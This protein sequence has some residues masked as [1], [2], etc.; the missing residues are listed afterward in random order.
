MVSF[1]STLFGFIRLIAKVKLSSKFG[2]SFLCNALY[3]PAIVAIQHCEQFHRY[4]QNLLSRG[5]AKKQIIVAVMKKIFLAAFAILKYD[6]KF[7]PD[8]IFKT[9]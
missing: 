6:C 2:N 4:S 3:F 7:D 9:H 1:P 8:L 5:K